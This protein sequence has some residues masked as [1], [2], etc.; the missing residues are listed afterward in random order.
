MPDSPDSSLNPLPQRPAEAAKAPASQ[1]SVFWNLLRPASWKI[2]W[3]W[4][5]H[6]W[7]Q[8]TAL[9]WGPKADPKTS[10]QARGVQFEESIRIAE[11]REAKKLD[12][13]VPKIALAFSGG[14][15][16]SA[17]FNLGVLQSMR[18]LGLLPFIQYLSTVSGGGYIGS[19]L[20][21]AYCRGR[22]ENALLPD[23]EE[24]NHLRQYSRYLSPETGI[25]SA[26]SWTIFSIW[27]RNTVLVQLPIILA[28][29]LILLSPRV[30]HALFWVFERTP[31]PTQALWVAPSLLCVAL[32]MYG[33][34]T[35]LKELQALWSNSPGHHSKAIVLR[36]ALPIFLSGTFGAA[37]IWTMAL[38]SQTVT[39][40][41]ANAPS[42]LEGAKAEGWRWLI[43]LVPAV[44]LTVFCG[45]VAFARRGMSKAGELARTDPGRVVRTLA[46]VVPGVTGGVAFVTL[47]WVA[48]LLSQGFWNR[49]DPWWP[50][51]GPS[52]M[53]IT[54]SLVVTLLIGVMGRDIPDSEREWWSRLTAWL[55]ITAAI[56]LIVSVISVPLPPALALLWEQMGDFT[57][58][59][60]ALLAWAA[61]TA[62]SV[63]AGQS[64]KSAEGGNRWMNLLAKAGPWIYMVGLLALLACGLDWAVNGLARSF[65]GHAG[66]AGPAWE[67]VASVVLAFIFT[68]GGMVAWTRFDLNE[69]SM[70][71]F[72]R[73]RLVRCYLGATNPLRNFNYFTGLDKYDD[74]RL[75][76]V[77]VSH[78]PEDRTVSNVEF[79]Y[80]GPFPILN[81][82]VNASHGGNLDEQDRR[83]RSFVFT[84]LYSGFDGVRLGWQ[85][86]IE[87]R[88]EFMRKATEQAD[89]A[90]M[91]AALATRTIA[92][93]RRS[94]MPAYRLTNDYIDPPSSPVSLRRPE[95]DASGL[96]AA[97]FGRVGGIKLG[98]AM[99]ISGAAAS[100]NMGFHTSPAVAFLLTMFNVRLGWWVPNPASEQQWQD[101]SPTFQLVYLLK[102]LFGS[103]DPRDPY[104]YL[105][106]GGHFENLGVYEL[107][108]RECDV[109]IS[110]DAEEDGLYQFQGL[111][112]VIRKCWIDFQV[113][114]EIDVHSIRPA[115]TGE[116]SNAHFA[117]GDIEYPSGRKGTFVYLKSSVTGD[118]YTGIL[119]YQQANLLFPHE[120]TSD[121]FFSEDQFE[122]YRALGQHVANSAFR[123]AWEQAS[124]FDVAA[125]KKA[126]YSPAQLFNQL[127]TQDFWDRFRDHLRNAR[128]ANVT[129]SSAFT[130][131]NDALT[132]IWSRIAAEPDLAYLDVELFPDRG[133]LSQSGAPSIASPETQRKVFYYSQ[134]LLQL[135][136][137]VY[138]DLD[139]ERTWNHPINQ[140][141]K[142]MFRHWGSSPTF[143]RAWEQTS[144]T[145]GRGFIDFCVSELGLTRPD[146][147]IRKDQDP[148]HNPAG[149]HSDGKS[150]AAG[151]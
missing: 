103:A 7:E 95:T 55:W 102:E 9:L 144:S 90:P 150:K 49:M 28:L 6:F 65:S 94:D 81:A 66:N 35:I 125:N 4:N 85:P 38:T 45:K 22:G 128:N 122:S 44:T 33:L 73:N 86:S 41:L 147:R 133:G 63:W 101:P 143:Q 69:F 12:P 47:G 141:W 126:A 54:F 136:E 89:L 31:V 62:G 93:V 121:Q 53:V 5:V 11:L 21:T 139:L 42:L 109:I 3:R 17:T 82:A 104:V 67:F 107:V 145:Y 18:D 57:W 83:A 123:S 75:A 78:V 120:P 60:G 84:P 80:V 134:E 91:P 27:L 1:P 37:A 77:I 127:N 79:P 129:S 30:I 114:I 29:N 112:G 146:F 98:T 76:D 116:L 23:S 87:K 16:R 2:W 24:V 43:H 117:V 151:V 14:G 25:L 56:G 148:L 52:F 96:D 137:N 149:P 105:S 71:H 15:I 132:R 46:M 131:H 124:D 74:K 70:H 88:R 20:I 99:A 111:A 118:E 138:V 8:T 10:E 40:R 19:F 140:G 39:T 135:M 32:L 108:R 61:S 115:S 106:D 97:G 50:L 36:A 110:C 13:G 64:E 26:D 51:V 58:K 72:Y 142:R 34:R 92:S 100:P 59:P 113:K 48:D 68:A 130:R 119:Q